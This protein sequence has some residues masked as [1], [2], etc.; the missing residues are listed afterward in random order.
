MKRNK[1][2]QK[3]FLG[4]ALVVVAAAVIFGTMGFSTQA[5]GGQKIVVHLQHWTDD[6]HAVFMAVKL[7]GA[8]QAKGAK[9]TLFASLEGARLA[10]GR[11]PIE[12]R[13]GMSASLSRHYKSF[14]EA[15][16]KVLVCPHCAAAAGMDA[17]SLRLGARIATE[18]EVVEVLLAAEKILDY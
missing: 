2:M 7:A 9:V 14:T 12:M 18:E 13:W 1:G 16:G 17:E 8:M 6:L 4:V 10:D 3:G 5:E 15:G 11:Q